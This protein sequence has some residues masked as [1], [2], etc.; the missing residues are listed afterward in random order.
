MAKV[1]AEQAQES[2]DSPKMVSIKHTRVM[3]NANG[4]DVTVMDYEEIKD[5]D[6]AITDAEAHKADLEARL[7]EC[8]QELVDYQAIKD[9][10]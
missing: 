7:A 10:E 6:Q 8:E 9:A 5:V 4:N 3:K 2:V 1:I